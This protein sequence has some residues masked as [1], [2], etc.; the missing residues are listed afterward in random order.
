MSAGQGGGLHDRLKGHRSARHARW[1]K[2]C[3][4][5]LAEWL[6]SNTPVAIV[7]DEVPEDADLWQ[8]EKQWIVKFSDQ[9]LYNKFGNPRWSP[10]RRGGDRHHPVA[11]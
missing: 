1:L 4:E 10:R 9:G 5:G 11:A 2:A 8:A 7:L 6:V 3:N